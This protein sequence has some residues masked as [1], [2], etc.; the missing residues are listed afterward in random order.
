MQEDKT[1]QTE[2]T[3]NTEAKKEWVAPTFEAITI[4]GG[5]AGPDDGLG[6]NGS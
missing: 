3:L 4:A 6:G 5:A 1:L 2:Q